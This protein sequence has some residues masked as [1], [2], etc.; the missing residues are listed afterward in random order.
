M[1]CEEA[2]RFL[3]AY[4]DR[5]LD[6]HRRLEI[7]EHLSSCPSCRSLAREIKEF[8]SFFAA[9]APYQ[10]PPQLRAKV[11]AVMRQDRAKPTFNLL[12]QPWVYAA[13][14]VVLSVFLALNI[15]FPQAEAELFREAVLRH[16]QSFAADHAVDVASGNPHIVKSWFAAKL[17]FVPP[18]V[19]FP[20]AGYS[21]VG[22]RIDMI[23]NHSVAAFVYKNNKDVVTMFCWPP[24]KEHLS[25]SDQLVEGYHVSTWSN[26]ECNYV[27]VSKLSDRE[28]EEF[29]DSFRVRVQSGA[30][31]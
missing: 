23:K 13:G 10:A 24:K 26:A 29:V 1:N 17:D 25:N 31:F 3:D 19:V 14:V 11:L 12:R 15:L 7:E 18:V 20:A 4:V 21:L 22:G 5:E 16:S 6:L 9:S 30:Y 28:M 8:R 27:L 2:H